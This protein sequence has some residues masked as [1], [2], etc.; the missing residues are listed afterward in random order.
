M[1]PRV[2]VKTL[3]DLNEM[4]SLHDEDEVMVSWKEH[5]SLSCRSTSMLC[6]C[7]KAIHFMFCHSLVPKPG[8]RLIL[9]VQLHL[10]DPYTHTH[11]HTSC[12][13]D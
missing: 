3:M 8:T 12:K 7:M 13:T 1:I 9:P 11:T 6:T 2:V 5:S 4:D 10:N